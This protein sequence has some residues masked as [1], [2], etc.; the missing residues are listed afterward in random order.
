MLSVGLAGSKN[1]RLL[2]HGNDGKLV[3]YVDAS[4]TAKPWGRSS[5]SITLRLPPGFGVCAVA[6]PPAATT[7]AMARAMGSACGKKRKR[8]IVFPSPCCGRIWRLPGSARRGCL[9][10]ENLGGAETGPRMRALYA[11]GFAA[12]TGGTAGRPRRPRGAALDEW[13]GAVNPRRVGIEAKA[14]ARCGPTT[15][16]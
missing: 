14:R 9:W 4:W 7:R 10:R 3:E 2:K 12:T 13:G 5:R 1:T 11:K 15:P 16:S 6:S 8:F